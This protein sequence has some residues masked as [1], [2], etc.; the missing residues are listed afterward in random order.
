[1]NRDKREPV[2]SATRHLGFSLDLKEK[3][4]SVTMRHTR[5]I[6]AHFNRFLAIVRK[7]GRIRVREVQR[8]LGLQIWISTVFTVARQFLTSTCDI[9]RVAGDGRFFYPRMHKPLVARTIFDLKF[10]RRFMAG[11]PRMS[12]KAILGLLPSN[13]HI[14]A[15]DA[16]TSWGMAGVITFG[17]GAPEYPGLD[18]L[19]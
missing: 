17:G 8:M 11:N 3:V 7:Q 2:L 5:K 9:L 1:M 10:W 18:G 19:F 6:T 13:T 4:L 14:L 16:C 15:C 12:F